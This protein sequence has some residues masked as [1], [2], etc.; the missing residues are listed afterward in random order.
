MKL[1]FSSVLVVCMVFGSFVWAQT[2]I[3]INEIHYDNAG[4]DIGEAIEIAGPAGTDL[5]GWSIVLYNGNGG[6]SYGTINLSD[7]IPD[8][9]NGFGTRS[10]L[11]SGIENGSPDGMALVD[12][13]SAV[14]QFLSYEGSLTAVDGPAIGMTSTDIGVS[15]SS[16]TPVGESLQLTGAG[17]LYNDFTWET[18]VTSTFGTVNIGQTFGGGTCG[19]S[20]NLHV[21]KISNADQVIVGDMIQYTITVTNNG[22]DTADN[23]IVTDT[24]PGSISVNSI[25]ISKGTCQ[26]TGTDVICELGTL[27]NAEIVTVTLAVETTVSGILTNTATVT[28]DTRDLIPADNTA[29]VQ[30]IVNSDTPQTTD[31]LINEADADTPG[32]DT[33]EFIELYDGGTGNTNLSG[34]VLVLFNGSNDLSYNAFDLDGYTTDT[35]GYF[36][37]GSVPGADLY[38]S[39]GW[40]QNGADA[41]A[42]YFGTAADFPNGSAVTTLNLVDALV[43]DTNDGDD[44]GLLALLPPGQPQINEGGAGDSALHS[45]Q[46]C[47]NGQGGQLNTGSYAQFEPSPGSANLCGA[48]VD[49]PPSVSST[50]PA[51]GAG[52]VATATNITINFSE[53][54]TVTDPWFTIMCSISG[55]HMATVSGGPQQY[56]LDPIS[57]FLSG[58]TCTV[59]VH[60][61]KVADRDEPVATMEADY[62]VSFTTL[63]VLSIT[64]IH[65]L[66]GSGAATPEAWAVHT[67]EG[68]VT[69]TMQGYAGQNGF[70]V[71]E[72]DADIDGDSLTSEGI[73]IDS[74]IPVVVG[75][76]VQVTGMVQERYE[77]TSIRDVSSVVIVSSGNPQPGISTVMLPV[78]SVD[79]WERY[80]GMLVTIPQTLYVSGNYTQGRYGEVDLSV[81]DRLWI[82][83][84]RVPPGD[85]AL[86]LQELNDRSRIQLDDGSTIENPPVV[87]YLGVDGTLRPGDTTPELTGIVSY[88]YS[89]YEIHPTAP[90]SFTRVN[91]RLAMPETVGGTLKVASFNVLNYFNGPAFP[92]PRG[93]NTPE[94]FARQ[95][96]KILAAILAMDADI[97]GLMEIENDGYGPESAIQDLVNGLNDTAGLG[98]YAFVNPGVAAIGGDEI[99]VGMVYRALTV[100]PRGEAAILD[101]SVDPN[102]LDTK[103]RPSLA[104]TFR[105][106]GTD[107]S[108]TVVVNHLKSKGSACD[109]VGDPMLS[110]G[111]ENCNGTRTK[112][113]EALV[114]WLATDPTG[115]G[116][117]DALIIGDLNAYAKEDPVTAIING[118]YTNLVAQ[119]IGADAYSYVFG[120]QSGYL[121]HALASST[122]TAQV[123][124]VTEWHINAD[125]PTAMDYNDYNQPDLYASDMY[126]ASDHDPVLIG[127]NLRSSFTATKDVSGI[128][129][130]TSTPE[131]DVYAGDIFTYYLEIE[132]PFEQAAYFAVSDPL[133]EYLEYISGPFTISSGGVLEYSELFAGDTLSLSFEVKVQDSAPVGWIIENIATIIAY[134]NP[135]DIERTTLAIVQAIAPTTN[136]VPEPSTLFLFGI[137]LMG[138]F[139]LLRRKH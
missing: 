101:S 8:Q 102:F 83:T 90:V 62:S 42:L 17:T 76:T 56:V 5:S 100:E 131:L 79:E 132:N 1:L 97:I 2:P 55:P 65:I 37:I 29:T 80:E 127:L 46:R 134:T 124:G 137:G 60:A 22:P 21:T 133:D 27:T 6:T 28:S 116:D 13:T 120:G 86:A 40:L 7:R 110:D 30:T 99:T 105:Q 72:E 24:L 111:Q 26:Q 9:C 66:Q 77:M 16:T 104:Q 64:P 85:G 44:A 118:G 11:K 92:T 41:V 54:V 103:N 129:R 81:N 89:T 32:T 10:Y 115:S 128:D 48:I 82:P 59:R 121:D 18:P 15:E 51:T 91:P 119:L 4:G 57:D 23:V 53:D 84:H 34:L 38:V 33:A 95:R 50:I 122:L 12:S 63:E 71:Q 25:S 14:V 108:V 3:F 112:A 117:P 61:D 31:V 138:G 88:N 45:N 52:D 43:Y 130:L 74:S 75:D 135:F 107:E 125:E 39:S 123:A 73:F 114:A 47:P 96:E 106:R 126:R 20:A 87:P 136:V 58:E 49:T 67:I 69:G 70:F 98:T 68:I 19:P 35:S 139:W 113:A 78:A 93:A 36:V 94:E 109:D